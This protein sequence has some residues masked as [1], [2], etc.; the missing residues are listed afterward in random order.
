MQSETI[1]K[2]K[3]KTGK[4][5]LITLVILII[6]GAGF[7]YYW[8][9]AS[10]D[11]TKANSAIS[12]LNV[13]V[14]SLQNQLTATNSQVA[15]L[16]DQLASS[17][18]SQQS[19]LTSANAQIASLKTQLTSANSQIASLQGI[20]GLS[21]SS[22]IVDSV[23]VNQS[24]GQLSTVASFPVDYAGY[25]VVSGTSTT[26]NGYIRVADSFDG[27]PYLSYNHPFGTGTTLRIPVLPGNVTV[28]FGNANA[29][30]GST[31][32]VTVIYNY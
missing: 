7:I 32:T 20:T 28:Y 26:P 9:T 8:M 19:Q 2:S 16:R 30:G 23:T 22:K 5:F 25:I 14:S 27:Y 3:V 6:V 1:E 4:A 29:F 17:N 24:A 21:Q 10:V 13:Q 15:S 12:S 31:A 11:I 18:T